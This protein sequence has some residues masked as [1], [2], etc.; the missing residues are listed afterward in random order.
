MSATDT[1]QELVDERDI[2]AVALRYCRALD[3]KDWPL[4]ADVFLPEATADLASPVHLEGIDA[5]TDR[6][7]T[8]LQHLDESQ[9]L[10]GN[11]E[12]TVD[13]NAGTHRCYLHAQHIRAAT[14]GGPHYIVAGRYEDRVVR[15][16]AGWRIA[17]RT[18]TVMWTEGNVAVTRP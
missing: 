3:T 15:T 14:D 6:I 16:D 8:A 2:V 5:I 18:L 4:L 17:H 7:R 10:V 11:H 9:H 13:G 1:L 12:V